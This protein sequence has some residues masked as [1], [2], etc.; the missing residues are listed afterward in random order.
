MGQSGSF[1]T[2]KKFMA[3]ENIGKHPSAMCLQVFPRVLQIPSVHDVSLWG[4]P[5]C[6]SSAS[7]SDNPNLTSEIW[8]ARTHNPQDLLSQTTVPWRREGFF[9]EIAV[10]LCVRSCWGTCQSASHVPDCS[11]SFA[12]K[13]TRVELETLHSTWVQSW[14][15]VKIWFYRPQFLTYLWIESWSMAGFSGYFDFLYVPLCF[16]ERKTLCCLEVWRLL[17]GLRVCV[18]VCVW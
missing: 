3:Y 16:R 18:C 1:N 2:Q 7:S 11:T 9:G 4:I 5:P 8:H 15:H 13:E 6:D 14:F 12:K 10:G 17:L